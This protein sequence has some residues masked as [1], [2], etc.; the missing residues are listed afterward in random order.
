MDKYQ[1]DFIFNLKS[2]RKEQ[3]ISQE[4]L[5]ELCN[6]ATST[7]GCIESAH[8]YPSFELITKIAESLQIHPADLFLKDASKQ[9]EREMYSKY[10]HTIRQLESIPVN[11]RQPIESMIS[12]M[13]N[14]YSVGL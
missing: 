2:Y 13:S 9:E 10:N 12:D 14:R 1:E 5:A 8:Q 6:V 11:S 7:I 4:K 3:G